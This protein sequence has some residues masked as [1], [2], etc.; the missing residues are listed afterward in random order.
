MQIYDEANNPPYVG[1][2]LKKILGIRSFDTRNNVKVTK[3]LKDGNKQYVI[4]TQASLIII[5]NL[6]KKNSDTRLYTNHTDDI[7][8]LDFDD[9]FDPEFDLN[10]KLN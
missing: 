4:Y 2:R 7:S 8:S 10:D 1:I 9:N 5:F 6:F 3:Y